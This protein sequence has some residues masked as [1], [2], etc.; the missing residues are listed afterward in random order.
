MKNFVFVILKYLEIFCMKSCV[1]GQRLWLSQNPGQAKVLA[2]LGPTF[3]GLAWPG[4]WPQ[5][6]AGTSLV[7]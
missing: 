3:F 7:L 4:L 5:A 2:W 1:P 6:G